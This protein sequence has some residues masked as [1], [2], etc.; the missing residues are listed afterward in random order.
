[1]S[2]LTVTWDAGDGDNTGFKVKLQDGTALLV[3]GGA[4]GTHK[5]EDLIAGKEFTVLVFTE[6]G[7]QKSESLTGSFRTSKCLNIL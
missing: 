4:T 5:F 3:T 7:D 6:S 2:S 1:M